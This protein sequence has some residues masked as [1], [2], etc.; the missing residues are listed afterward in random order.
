MN[1][2]SSAH[3]RRTLA[4]TF[5][6]LVTAGVPLWSAHAELTPPDDGTAIDGFP[7]SRDGA[8]IDE[9]PDHAS[10]LI[11]EVVPDS[12][13]DRNA[14]PD[15]P[16]EP[17]DG[18]SC[19]DPPPLIG[20]RFSDLPSVKSIRRDRRFS[21]LVGLSGGV[22]IPSSKLELESDTQEL[23]TGLSPASLA[24]H[25]GVTLPV[26][27]R[28]ELMPRFGGQFVRQQ[29][30][31]AMEPNIELRARVFPGRPGRKWEEYFV[32]GAGYGHLVHLVRLR[33]D[34]GGPGQPTPYRDMQRVAAGPIRTVGGMGAAWRGSK[35]VGVNIEGDIYVLAPAWSIH[36]DLGVSLSICLW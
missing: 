26:G 19:V 24:F 28:W 32:I 5:V 11:G 27:R 6:A 8:T 23:V 29:G 25:V 12:N 13:A 20:P 21:A 15:P 22:G 18:E 4:A 30:A 31:M 9:E 35:R 34:S 36:F 7:A 3:A 17:A 16:P 10:N 1:L 14:E 2:Y 33:D